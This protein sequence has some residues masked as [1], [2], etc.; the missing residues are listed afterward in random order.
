VSDGNGTVATVD[1]EGEEDVKKDE[2]FEECFGR[3]LTEIGI[4]N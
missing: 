4:S 1:W 3:L 2:K